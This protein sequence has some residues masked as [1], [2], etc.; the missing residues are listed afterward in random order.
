[1]RVS[2]EEMRLRRTI[3]KI[4]QISLSLLQRK[5]EQKKFSI[6]MNSN[7]SEITLQV[8]R[9]KIAKS[10]KNSPILHNIAAIKARRVEKFNKFSW[11]LSLGCFRFDFELMYTLEGNQ[12]E[13]IIKARMKIEKKT[14]HFCFISFF[15]ILS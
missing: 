10:I 7:K 8:V 3:K 15:A 9:H 13:R 2:E 11:F 4:Y 1:M 6:S 14:S 5:H 12:Q